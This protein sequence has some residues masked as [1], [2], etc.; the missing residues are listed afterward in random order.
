VLIA[1]HDPLLALIGDKRIALHN[2]RISAPIVTSEA[3]RRNL[4]EPER[5]DHALLMA[6]ERLLRGAPL[7]EPIDFV[8]G[9]EW[10]TGT[11]NRSARSLPCC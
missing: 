10:V 2:G 3:E 8:S 1:T 6:R 9:A 5:L 11:D 7:D 4:R